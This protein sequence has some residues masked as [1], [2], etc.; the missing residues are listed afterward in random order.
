[1]CLLMA[2]CTYTSASKEPAQNC[3]SEHRTTNMKK[4]HR[5][6]RRLSSRAG[7]LSANRFPVT[8]IG[9]PAMNFAG[10]ALL[11]SECT[12]SNRRRVHALHSR[13]FSIDLVCNKH[14]TSTQT[15]AGNISVCF[16]SGALIVNLKNILGRIADT[17]C[18]RCPPYSVVC[19]SV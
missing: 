14:G 9:W 16:C 7:L 15:T 19:V 11:K 18:Y 5:L 6:H 2:N 10:G 1:M 8:L 12:L 3:R 4:N 13:L 17:L